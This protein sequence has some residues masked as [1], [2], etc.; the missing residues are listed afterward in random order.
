MSRARTS[1]ATESSVPVAASA[2]SAVTVNANRAGRP[3]LVTAKNASNAESASYAVTVSAK[4][5]VKRHAP[6]SFANARNV[7]YAAIANAAK[8]V[9]AT[10]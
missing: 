2:V 6:A 7:R 5:A 10:G 4:I 1:A 9:A 8:K 3:V